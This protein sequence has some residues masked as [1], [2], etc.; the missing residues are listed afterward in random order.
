[1]TLSPETPLHHQSGAALVIA[2]LL[3]IVLSLL[4]AQAMSSAGLQEQLAAGQRNVLLA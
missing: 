1:M 2:M 4:G 3:L